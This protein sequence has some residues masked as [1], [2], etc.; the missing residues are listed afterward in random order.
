MDI[1]TSLT[2]AAEVAT[3]TKNGATRRKS[4]RVSHAP[5]VFS[6]ELYE[7]SVLSSAKRKRQSTATHQDA[8]ADEEDEDDEDEEES[9][10]S[11]DAEPDEEEL[12]DQRRRQK[13]K[14]SIAAKPAAKRTKT[15]NGAS[16]TLAIRSSGAAGN[17]T[18]KQR[19]RA[20]PNPVAMTGLYA[21][22]FGR[23]LSADAAAARWHAQLEKDDVGA[24]R[25]LVNLMI[26]AV[27]CEISLES[28]DIEDVDN[29]TDRLQD[30]VT[31]YAM[32]DHSDYPLS[33][34]QKQYA[35]MHDTLHN[36]F[37]S[38]VH[39]L[40]NSST[41]Y[42][43]PAIYEN[44]WTW[45]ACMCSAGHRSFRHT[46]AVITLAMLT[47]LTEVAKE[48]ESSMAT[49]KTQLE[50]E[51]KK[52]K[53]QNK[54]RVSQLQSDSSKE[55]KQLKKIDDLAKDGFDTVY[56]HRYR[57][58]DE[59]IRFECATALGLWMRNYR[60]VFLQGEYLRYWGWAAS[61]PY[62]PTR[63]EVMRQLKTLVRDRQN[64]SSMRPYL[65]RFRPRIVE[66]GARDADTTARVEA[67]ELLGQLRDADLLEP[68]DV[69]T[70]GQLIFDHEAKVRKAVAGFFKSNIQDA[71]DAIVEDFDQEQLNEVLP[72]HDDEEDYREP[73]KSWIK[74]KCL[75]QSL[76]L[77]SHEESR[78]NPK[79]LNIFSSE[80]VDSRYMVATQAIYKSMPELEHWRR[81]AGYL[82]HDHST[83]STAE[84][85]NDVTTLIGRVYVIDEGEE[86]VLLDVLFT[87]VKL[88]L[89]DGDDKAGTRTK[90]AKDQTQ[91]RREQAAQVLSKVIPQLHD[92]YGSSPHAAASILR[93]YQLY[94]ADLLDD[95]QE[96]STTQATLLN[97]VDRQ[98]TT[99]TDAEVLAEASRALRTAQMHDNSKEAADAKIAELWS[100]SSRKLAT[101][102]SGKI[103]AARGTLDHKSLR[104]V[105]DT[106]GRLSQLASVNDCTNS[107][108]ARVN[109]PKSKAN[110]GRKE[111]L[112]QLMLEILKRGVPDD[113]TPD[114]VES[115][116]GQLCIFTIR[117][118]L[119]YMKW[120][121]VS[122]QSAIRSNLSS[123]SQ[124]RDLQSLRSEK[125]EF[126]AR[127]S[128]VMTAR[129]P[130]DVV[131]TTSIL[132]LLELDVLLATL[133]N[134]RPDRDELDEE[135]QTSIA[136]LVVKIDEPTSRVVL[137]THERMEKRLAMRLKKKID[138]PLAEAKRSAKRS[139]R[140]SSAALEISRGSAKDG[141]TGD[142][143][144]EDI[145][146]PPEDSDD[147]RE[148]QRRKQRAAQDSDDENLSPSSDDDGG[149]ADDAAES[150][151]PAQQRRE[152]KEKARL[153]AETALC[154]LTA[155]LVFAIV[156]DILPDSVAVRTR[157]QINRTRLGKSYAQVIAYLDDKKTTKSKGRGKMRM[158][159]ASNVTPSKSRKSEIGGRTTLSEPLVLEDDDIEDDE[160]NEAAK[161]DEEENTGQQG[162]ADDPIEEADEEMREAHEDE[163]ILGD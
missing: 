116:E 38:V 162:L 68:D 146:R 58:V 6:Q 113:S 73:D 54:K 29:V 15:A 102:L 23:E 39:A 107:L 114:E 125:D 60:T 74:F 57:D 18:A 151:A 118:V 59:K 75:A 93:L 105:T 11:E 65:E 69:D 47:G 32:Q 56:T 115:M 45:P 33:G 40:H 94:D 66:I 131:R 130:L 63:I 83:S 30:V 67:L 158:S 27:G 79:A 109:W 8:D 43:V 20:Q 152:A 137:E 1:H 100:E 134:L 142:Q 148:T 89:G 22:V 55:Q 77:G 87:V 44:I 36:F 139:A 150:S 110:Q 92:K 53:S 90:Q 141:A 14:K 161:H 129:K 108:N 64:I 24:I 101:L 51:T 136:D 70:I 42:R 140:H 61:D 52:R 135:A 19:P 9:D 132:A 72:D 120:R 127:L 126:R 81:L 62:A 99:Q 49:T 50:T 35:G 2:M 153:L 112:L 138:L 84:H 71:Y 147:E 143:Q 157:L 91:R 124:L 3:A 98:F 111:T 155:K 97:V 41:L 46:A 16:T 48:I 123:A 106:V 82:L 85:S 160:E 4:G 96:T 88:S 31:E 159:T 128:S 12:R 80:H 34:K 119:F 21:D 13:S 17:K 37:K 28:Q 156:A 86:L 122:L 145:D 144:E 10:E 104:Q 154:E 76:A 121:I 163:E 5:A 133:R 103:V 7:G 78:A 117:V 95:V 25:D 149:E 26:H